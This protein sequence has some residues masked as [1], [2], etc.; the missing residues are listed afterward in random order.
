[1][2][3]KLLIFLYEKSFDLL[4]VSC[5]FFCKILNKRCTR[6]F[7]KYLF[8]YNKHS[9][10]EG[11]LPYF[12]L[13]PSLEDFKFDLKSGKDFDFYHLAPL[14][15]SN[16]ANHGI[17]GLTIRMSAYIYGVAKNNKAKKAIDVG[18]YKGGSA[19]LLSVALG[20]TGKVW[21]IDNFEK[22]KRLSKTNKNY[23]LLEKFSK[24]NS[25]NIKQ[26]VGDSQIVKIPNEIRKVDIV[27]IDGGHTYEIVKNDYKKYS[28]YLKVGGSLF[29]DDCSFE[30]TF[31]EK[32][33]TLY[34]K[35]LIDEIVKS[36]KFK[37]IKTVDR[38]G[39][40]IK[41]K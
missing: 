40:F 30:G 25:L 2:L 12:N 38:L 24:R 33:S 1:M 14:F 34:M 22:E 31:S 18:T 17:L 41:I 29:F 23:D 4:E 27:L 19:I 20:K 8:K 11:F 36:K 3:K 39:H 21:T 5:K 15:A 35:P 9:F 10:F 26:I 28:Q 13:T 16:N 7:S 37:F 32:N 6:Y